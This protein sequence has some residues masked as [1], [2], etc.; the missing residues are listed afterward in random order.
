MTLH[1]AY[2]LTSNRDLEMIALDEALGRMRAISER[3]TTIAQQRIFGGVGSEDAARMLN[4]T[5]RT[6]D[7]DWKWAQA[8]LRRELGDR[9]EA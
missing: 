1:D 2:A 8:W 5:P 7:R 6:V 3:A 4:V 9:S